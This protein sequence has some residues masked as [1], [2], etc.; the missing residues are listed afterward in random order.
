VRVSAAVSAY[1]RTY[2][3]H[4]LKEAVESRTRLQHSARLSA[5][6]MTYATHALKEAVK[7]A[8]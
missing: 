8:V 2:E 7:E 3:T 1:L 4:A 5:Y 6:L